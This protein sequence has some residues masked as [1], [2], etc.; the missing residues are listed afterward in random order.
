MDVAQINNNQQQN[1]LYK[2]VNDL[3][4]K[5][6][7]L[8]E[9][10][11][12][13]EKL[14]N[15]NGNNILNL[16]RN[17]GLVYKYILDFKNE[18]KINPRELNAKILKLED[19]N[20]ND[21]K[22]KN[23]KNEYK[24][25][26]KKIDNKFKELKMEI[27]KFKNDIDMKNKELDK[28]QNSVIKKNRGLDQL[29][30]MVNM[31]NKELEQLKNDI[32]NKS[33]ILKIDENEEKSVF[34]KFENLIA[35]VM[36]KNNIN[37]DDLKKFEKIC[38]KLM[39]NDISPLNQLN[40]YFSDT[41]NLLFNKNE[42]SDVHNKNLD[43]YVEIKNN[44]YSEIEKIENKLNEQFKNN[45]KN[46]EQTK[47]PKNDIEKFRMEFKIQKSDASDEEIKEHLNKYKDPNKA[48]QVL[49]QKFMK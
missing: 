34:E 11:T 42:L 31:K 13:N 46:V 39:K 1:D 3:R 38:K 25:M 37:T 43:K 49:M 44:I 40:K 19:N 21:E 24:E 5:I 47:K 41:D 36:F 4:D 28:L 29:K 9:K 23:I 14:S 2:I 30:N 32:S 15:K 6:K 35:Q 20:L 12:I 45:P 17:I 16:N 33:E 26:N 7:I 27:E 22:I 8:E 48:Y 18:F 10:Q